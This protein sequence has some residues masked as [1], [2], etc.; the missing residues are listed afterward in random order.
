MSDV[1]I[2]IENI[3]PKSIDNATLNVTDKPTKSIGTYIDDLLFLVLGGFHQNMEK[4]RIK[5]N[6]DL[7]KFENDVKQEISAIPPEKQIEPKT[8]LILSTLDAARYKVEEE[9]L[10]KMFARTIANSMN[11]DY[12]NYVHPSFVTIVKEMS[13]LDAENISLFKNKTGFPIAQYIVTSKSHLKRCP[14]PNIFLSNPNNLDIKSVGVSISFL[15]KSGLVKVDYT[16]YFPSEDYNIFK[17][18]PEFKAIQNQIDDVNQLLPEEI[19]KLDDT[20]RE[21]YY[22]LHEANIEIQKGMIELTEIGERFV[23]ICV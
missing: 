16:K 1:K 17:L 23:E 7:I 14:Y 11:S 4:R 19:I 12:A 20:A 3:V 8:G 15:V 21:N 22:F 6:E 18:T 2:G 10:R 5:Y 13:S 9:N